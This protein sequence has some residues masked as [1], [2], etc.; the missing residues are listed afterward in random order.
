MAN[1]PILSPD[2][3]SPGLWA[4]R[5]IND[6]Y[7]R[8]LENQYY[9]RNIESEILNRNQ[10]SRLLGE[11]AQWYGPKSQAEIDLINQG[12][13]PYYLAQSREIDMGRIPHFQ[14]Q[15]RLLGEQAQDVGYGNKLKGAQ[16]KEWKRLQ[17]EMDELNGATGQQAQP[18]QMSQYIPESYFTPEMKR[19]IE[20]SNRIV[21]LRNAGKDVIQGQPAIASQQQNNPFAPA[22]Q[23]IDEAMGQLNQPRKDPQQQQEAPQYLGEANQQLQTAAQQLPVD[24]EKRMAQIRARQQEILGN[25]GKGGRAAAETPEEKRR[26]TLEVERGKQDIRAYTK[27]MESAKIKSDAS[28]DV[29]KNIATLKE[30]SKKLG[31]YESGPFFGNLPAMSDAAQEVDKALNTIVKNQ[32][33]ATKGQGPSS[34]FKIRQIEKTKPGRSMNPAAREKVAGMIGAM[35][36]RTTEQ[37][38]FYT[39][40]QDSGFTSKEAES[41]WNLYDQERPEYNAKTGK[42][43]GYNL[44]TYEDYM[45][46]DALDAAKKGKS[47]SPREKGDSTSDIDEEKIAYTAKKYN[48]SIE[49]VK[50][51]MGIQ[52]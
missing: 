30:N 38:P 6:I 33:D 22:P 11:Q 40:A 21:D 3:A 43:N 52:S 29:L 27:I 14:A 26:G 13:I 47:Y 5:N 34:E 4:S 49:D 16:W 36:K 19:Q 17:D 28:A 12:H 39:L 51:K 2:Q 31:A 46:K 1:F 32:M 45:N 20:E 23:R 35:A 48:M 10:H 37:L 18:S 41:L 25:I 9:G 7:K 15:N 50:K 44:K 8:M 24:R 42:E